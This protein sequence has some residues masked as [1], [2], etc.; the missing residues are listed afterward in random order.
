MS[1]LEH[2]ATAPEPLQ[3]RLELQ[4][5]APDQLLALQALARTFNW[6]LTPLEDATG[7]P[8]ARPNIISPQDFSA[9]SEKMYGTSIYGLNAAHFLD[10]IRHG[11]EAVVIR[12]QYRVELSGSSYYYHD[13][14]LGPSLLSD[15]D[16]KLLAERRILA[17]NLPFEYSLVRNTEPKDSRFDFNTK[18]YDALF[19]QISPRRLREFVESRG[20]SQ[21]QLSAG[22]GKL[23]NLLLQAADIEPVKL[24]STDQEQFITQE[25]VVSAAK[26]AGLNAGMRER[27]MHDNVAWAL[28][29]QL[30]DGKPRSHPEMKVEGR[31]T[32][33][34]FFLDIVYGGIA[35]S[36]LQEL[37]EVYRQVGNS[38]VKAFLRDLPDYLEA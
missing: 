21:H 33:G 8:D 27:V 20:Y 19:G 1:E 29:D 32:V 16:A 14:T 24:V 37:G 26:K 36:S 9:A 18:I 13:Q 17:A 2:P 7:E 25:Q 34:K 30:K 10:N 5:D 11:A 3:Y 35:V 38:P 31:Y 28:H 4:T 12:N 22:H 6:N 15:N 23:L